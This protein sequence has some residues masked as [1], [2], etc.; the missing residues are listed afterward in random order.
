MF[1]FSQS[2]HIFSN[3]QKFKRKRQEIQN[4][5]SR[6]TKNSTLSNL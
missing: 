6:F 3:K 2:K 1:S 4:R 5:N